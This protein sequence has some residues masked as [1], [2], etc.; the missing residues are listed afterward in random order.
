MRLRKRDLSTV[1]LKERLT[2]QDDEGNF[3]EGF[4]MNQQRFK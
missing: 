3:Q 1:Y 4:Q 2:G